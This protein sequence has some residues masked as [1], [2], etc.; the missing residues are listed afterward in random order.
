MPC[1]SFSYHEGYQTCQQSFSNRLLLE[2]DANSLPLV[3]FREM[4]H[5]EIHKVPVV[6]R[7]DEM[8]Q[9][10]DLKPGALIILDSLDHPRHELAV[11]DL[12]HS[13]KR[14]PCGRHKVSGID[15]H[16]TIFCGVWYTAHCRWL[17]GRFLFWH[18]DR[19]G[20]RS[21]C[22]GFRGSNRPERLANRRFVAVS[23]TAPAS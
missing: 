21:V 23:G 2:P 19:G 18:V 12:A 17:R 15:G 16:G 22:P 13:V 1:R 20:P 9:A 5:S 6:L 11:M 3:Q 4:R 7:G 8:D 14:L 10:P